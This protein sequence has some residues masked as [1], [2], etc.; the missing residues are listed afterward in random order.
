MSLGM[1]D[2]LYNLEE[3]KK[4]ETWVQTKIPVDEIGIATSAESEKSVTDNL[5][6]QPAGEHIST[7][8]SDPDD[9][10]AWR[11]ER[12]NSSSQRQAANLVIVMLKTLSSPLQG[13]REL[14]NTGLGPEAVG[15]RLYF[16][17]CGIAA[18]SEFINLI[19]DADAT[20]HS[21]LIAAILLFIA[22]FFGYYTALLFASM[23]LPKEERKILNTNF[24][25]SFLMIA[26]STLVLFYI[27]YN[28]IPILGP[29]IGFFPLWTVYSIYKG[30]KVVKLLRVREEYTSRVWIVLSAACIISPMF[31]NW[32]LDELIPN[33][34]Q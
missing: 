30:V 2:N 14:K 23:L 27:L 19:Y 1:N 17:M 22:F 16:P 21:C 34:L 12:H 8:G 33:T 10:L 11:G 18:C 24:A 25:K 20:V 15:C 7:D 6:E 26:M 32:L 29:V 9:A 3:D 28:I 5:P 4:T 13:W 31:W